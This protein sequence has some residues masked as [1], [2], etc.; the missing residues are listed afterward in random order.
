MKED[1]YFI[2]HA[3]FKNKVGITKR[4]KKRTKEQGLTLG[5]DC[6]VIATVS[7]KL[8]PKVAG[9]IEFL[10]ADYFGYKKSQ[11]YDIGR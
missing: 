9:D 8:G 2:Y 6:E 1:C 11:H 3:P 7:R 5:Q 4:L 10:L